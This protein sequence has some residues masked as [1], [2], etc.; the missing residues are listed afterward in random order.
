MDRKQSQYYRQGGGVV[1]KFRASPNIS[2]MLQSDY[3]FVI[4]KTAWY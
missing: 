2:I 4:A 1:T 3:L